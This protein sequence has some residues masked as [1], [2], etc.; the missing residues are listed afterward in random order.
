[1]SLNL[2][3]EQRR[4][5]TTLA[6]GAVLLFVALVLTVQ[7]RARAQSTGP[8][9]EPVDV[10]APESAGVDTFGVLLCDSYQNL[11]ILWGKS[12]E[13]GSGIYYRTDANGSLSYP[14]DVLAM[15]TSRAIRLSAAIAE[16]GDTI[17]LL[18]QDSY[19]QG[20]V[21][22]SRAGLAEAARPNGW[23]RPE[24]IVPRADSALVVAGPGGGVHLIYGVSDNGGLRNVSYHSR[25]V[26]GGTRWSEPAVI[27]QADSEV[28]S[29][30]ILAADADDAGRLHVGLTT[31]SQEYGV[32]SEL[33]YVRSLD[34]GENW[35]PHQ[36]VA[37]QGEATPNVSVLAPFAFGEDEIHLTWHD[38]RRMHMWS[39]DGGQSWS[40]PGQIIEL[41]AGFG[42]ANFL[43]KDSA[44]QLHA[45][46]AVKNGVYSAAWDGSS[47]GGY[48]QIEDRSMDPHGQQLVACQGN[49]LHVVYDDR[50]EDDTTVW[51]ARRQVDAP[52]ID[53]API[54]ATDRAIKAD[55]ARPEVREQ[56]PQSP[57]A[58]TGSDDSSPLPFDTAR[59]I[60]VSPATPLLA[61][62]AAVTLLLFIVL[63]W[64]RRR[65][66]RR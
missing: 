9:T 19:V 31:R 12:H 30:L 28:P 65:R 62:M 44:D 29:F 45:V 64:R 20:N 48:V 27:S 39:R 7:G 43:A 59:P 47:W 23:T 50:V 52:H 42:G 55:T 37:R 6:A 63:S 61:A 57:M 11:H 4:S 66:G 33:V 1:M 56:Q 60:A 17:H 35:E 32:A 16:G 24:L 2:I 25:L 5:F 49:Q 46:V 14:T 3:N 21:Y 26:D 40:I 15:A 58:E 41:G 51:Y 53:Q 18:W 22:Y 34:A 36:S 8:W 54:P 10:S 38:P 13:E